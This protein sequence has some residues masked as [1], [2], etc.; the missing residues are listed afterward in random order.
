MVDAARW[1]D[2]RGASEWVTH[3]TL[4]DQADPTARDTDRE[5][6]RKQESLARALARCPQRFQ[7]WPPAVRFTFVM[8]HYGPPVRVWQWLRSLAFTYRRGGDLVELCEGA[9][10]VG[11]ANAILEAGEAVGFLLRG[12]IDLTDSGKAGAGMRYGG[13]TFGTGVRSLGSNWPKEP[14]DFAWTLTDR[15]R[16]VIGWANRSCSQTRP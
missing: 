6:Y 15:G 2:W 14:R 4:I 11:S 10:N 8:S 13:A 5:T 1:Y 9:G 7:A 12:K 3:C 16:A